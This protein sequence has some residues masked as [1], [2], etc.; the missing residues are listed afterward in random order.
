M[1]AGNMACKR[2]M[3]LF[4]GLFSFEPQLCSEFSAVKPFPVGFHQTRRRVR[5]HEHMHH[6][7][8]YNVLHLR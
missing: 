3:L 2:I 7:Q 5:C 4:H 1:L 8:A 6:R